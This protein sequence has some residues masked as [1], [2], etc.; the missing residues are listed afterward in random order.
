[1]THDTPRTRPTVWQHVTYSYGRK[2]PDSMRDWVAEDLAGKG[3]A[4]R[5]VIRVSVPCVLLLAPLLLIPT[6]A[7]VHASMTLPILI[8]FIYFSIALNRVWRRHRLTQHGLDPA[9]ADQRQLARE[10]DQRAAYERRYGPR[11]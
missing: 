8:P 10:A 11:A 4:T 5:M 9:L 1:M 7:Y 2:L 6:S 3:A